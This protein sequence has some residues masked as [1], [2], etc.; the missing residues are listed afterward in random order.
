MIYPPRRIYIDKSKIHG[1]GVFAFD[2]ISKGE[3]IEVCPIIDTGMSKGEIS[4]ILIDYRFNWPQGTPEFEKQ[5]VC[6][7]YGMLYNHSETPNAAWRSNTETNCFEF[8][9]TKNINPF[10]EIL[11]WYGDVNYWNDGR[12]HIEVK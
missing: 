2:Y 10:D 12:N 8:Y 4:H 6:S 3:I 1:L 11:I 5:V 7:G 9:A